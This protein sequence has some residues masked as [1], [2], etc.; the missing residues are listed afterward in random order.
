MKKI[1]VAVIGCGTISV[2]HLDSAASLS[3]ANLV[4]VCDI[5]E[6]RVN[7][8]AEKYNCKA[9]TDYKEMF[10]NEKLDAVHICL[11]HYLH[12]AVSRDAFEN[13]INVLCEKPMSIDYDDA[14]K[15][16]K[17]AKD[18]NLLY[19]VIFQCRYNTPAQKVKEYIN[20]GKLGR[21]KSAVSIL[22]WNRSDEY[23]CLS[24]WKGTWDKEGGGVVIDQAIHS[25]DLTNWLIDS[26]VKS[27]KSALYN[28]HHK[29]IDVEDTA[30]GI[31]EYENGT[32][33]TFFAMNNFGVDAP[34]E[35]RLV[36]ENGYVNLSYEFAD[37]TFSDGTKE[38]IENHNQ[39]IVSYSG[40]KDY[41]GTQHAVQINNFYNAVL[42]LEPLEITA[43][44]ALKTQK[45]I[46][47]IYKSSKL[48]LKK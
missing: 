12:T 17:L 27:V 39:K 4:A 37:I 28:R 22:T 41:W 21:V 5:K 35:I 3:Q 7:K 11:P 14:E 45:I 24:D 30:D 36:C 26:E 1:N 34:I 9:Y 46:C 16:L 38:H 20:S 13:G 32:T 48:N 29:I 25:I 18:K 47:E 8:T 19:G 42:G 23:Y 44:S 2:M 6:D 15:T 43:E 40:G 33:Y 31:I 10:R